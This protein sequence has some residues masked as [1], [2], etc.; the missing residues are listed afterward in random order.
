MWDINN[1]AA[2]IEYLSNEKGIRSVLIGASSDA[3]LY[4]KMK[5]NQELKLKPVN[6][7]GKA[8]IKERTEF[9]G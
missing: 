4:N 1:F 8:G 7:C 2:V 6:L 5:F 9:D 3:E